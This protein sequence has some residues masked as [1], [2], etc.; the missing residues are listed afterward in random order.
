MGLA[1]AVARATIVDW[2]VGVATAV[3]GVSGVVAPRCACR[4]VIGG[5]CGSFAGCEVTLTSLEFP[6][7]FGR[8]SYRLV[9]SER[10]AYRVGGR[11]IDRLIAFGRESHDSSTSRL[12][13]L[14]SVSGLVTST[15]LDLCPVITICSYICEIAAPSCCLGLIA[16]HFFALSTE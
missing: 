8:V 2:V 14:P 15:Y 16:Y 5:S 4:R 1:G 6:S 13:F 10:S 11:S 7:F 12:L 9:A 3:T